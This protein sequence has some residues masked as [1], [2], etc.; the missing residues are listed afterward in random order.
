MSLIQK[1]TRVVTLAPGA[2]GSI[3][4]F[5]LASLRT[6]T[7][8]NTSPC[9]PQ[10]IASATLTAGDGTVS[11]FDINGTVLYVTGGSSSVPSSSNFYC[12]NIANPNAPV[13]LSV[14]A[15]SSGG[16]PPTTFGFGPVA[17]LSAANVYLVSFAAAGPGN[18][19]ARVNATTPSAPT[20]TSLITV[21]E[22]NTGVS[23]IAGI[24]AGN[25]LV[26]LGGKNAAGTHGLLGIYNSGLVLQG[27]LT[28]DGVGSLLLSGTTVF[29]VSGT[30]FVVINASV[31]AAPALSGSATMPDGVGGNNGNQPL[32]IDAATGFVYVL[33]NG[34]LHNNPNVY[35]YNVSVPSAPALIQTIPVASSGQLLNSIMVANGTVNITTGF[36]TGLLVYSTAGALLASTAIA[37]ATGNSSGAIALGK[38]VA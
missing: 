22:F 25:S 16:N 4:A 17:H 21:A 19:V 8:Q 6:W 36:G 14:T 20:L 29:A 33:S 24:Q 3:L 11:Q 12:F 31:P 38:A 18:V 1:Q 32:A 2:G 26:Y 35:V 28:D 7:W 34:T 23:S 13:Q 30:R 10:Q 27:S 5:I 9:S 37:G 15:F